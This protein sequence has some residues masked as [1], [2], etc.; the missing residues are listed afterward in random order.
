VTNFSGH[1]VRF[2]LAV[3]LISAKG[4]HSKFEPVEL[5][6]SAI[7][8]SFRHCIRIF[9]RGMHALDIMN[10]IL[11]QQLEDISCALAIALDSEGFRAYCVRLSLSEHLPSST[12]VSAGKRLVG[13]LLQYL[14]LEDTSALFSH[15]NSRR[16]A[17][18]RLASLGVAILRYRA[19]VN[20]S[21]S[22]QSCIWLKDG[23]PI[24]P[25]VTPF[26]IMDRIGI[27]TMSA[28]GIKSDENMAELKSM[29]QVAARPT[30]LKRSLRPEKRKDYKETR[31]RHRRVAKEVGVGRNGVCAVM[32]SLTRYLKGFRMCLGHFDFPAPLH[33]DDDIDK[34]IIMSSPTL[35]V[36]KLP[37]TLALCDTNIPPVAEAVTI[38]QP[39]AAVV[40]LGLPSIPTVPVREAPAVVIPNSVSFGTACKAQV[41]AGFRQL[42][43]EIGSSVVGVS[44]PCNQTEFRVLVLRQLTTNGV[45]RTVLPES[46]T[47]FA[48]CDLHGIFQ[49]M[50]MKDGE[51]VS[52]PFLIRLLVLHILSSLESGHYQLFNDR[53]LPLLNFIYG[54]A[55]NPEYPTLHDLVELKT[56]FKL[57]VTLGQFEDAQFPTSTSLKLKWKDQFKNW[58]LRKTA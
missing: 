44:H 45:K 30:G 19:D 10:N 58:F 9:A 5:Q 57:L 35:P 25:V 33:S 1:S 23:M 20:L 28:S 22:E 15:N 11:L 54:N 24:S 42:E 26:S 3:G 50:A 37:V 39:S 31:R 4:H 38:A 41:W 36:E 34:P 8:A 49:L 40:Q 27:L 46:V 17:P 16:F 7:S 43:Q 53:V 14:E 2:N 12:M 18:N 32:L 29:I 51:Q 13:H 21:K 55:E 6:Q 48:Q 52:G 47:T 56:D